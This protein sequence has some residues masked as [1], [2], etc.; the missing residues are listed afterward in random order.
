MIDGHIHYAEC[1]GE[2]RML[3]VIE[4]NNLTGVGLQCIPKGGVLKVEEDAF[5][6]KEKCKV[7]VYIFGGIGRE[8]Y[9]LPE[10]KMGK[11]LLAEAKRLMAMGC[12][13]IKMLEAKPQVR[14]AHPIPDFDRSV[15]DEYF[16][17][18]EKERIPVYM[19]VNDPEEFWDASKVSDFAKKAGWFY[20]ENYINNEEQYRQILKRLEKHPRLKILFPHFFFMS[21]QLERLSK[22]LDQYP[23]V[24][25]DVTPGVELFLNLSDDIENAKSFFEKYQDRILYGTD[26]GARSVIKK[27][28]AL[29]SIEESRARVSLVTGFLEEKGEYLLYPDAYYAGDSPRVMHGLGLSQVQLKKMYEENFLIFIDKI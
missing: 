3:S 2:D 14:K 13:G 4:E 24:R 1:I 17:Y 21:K 9:D 6:L 27:E 18:L 22:I 12:T 16:S 25:I 15:W 19:H 20:D 10:E 7:P 11:A 29:L 28:K 5:R 23:E 26:I 8:I